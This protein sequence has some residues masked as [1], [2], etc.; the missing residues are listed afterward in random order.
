MVR[1]NDFLFSVSLINVD[2][3]DPWHMLPVALVKTVASH[4]EDA[5]IVRSFSKVHLPNQH[6]QYATS[7]LGKQM[8]LAANRRIAA[9]PAPARA[10]AQRRR[11]LQL[12]ALVAAGDMAV[13][14]RGNSCSVCDILAGT[15]DV[16]RRDLFKRAPGKNQYLAPRDLDLRPDAT[17][18]ER[19]FTARLLAVARDPLVAGLV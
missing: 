10:T 15:E 18:N 7:C 11:L 16:A 8:S 19:N 13:L 1:I 12:R 6:C 4:M 9:Q 14:S 5:Q 17:Y 2:Q 3:A